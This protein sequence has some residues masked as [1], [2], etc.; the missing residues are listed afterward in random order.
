MDH[1]N[2]NIDNSK[3]LLGIPAFLM[4]VLSLVLTEILNIFKTC[5]GGFL[6]ACGMIFK[7]AT[8]MFLNMII[9]NPVYAVL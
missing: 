1:E 2:I 4:G 9:Y 7:V 5:F 8:T 6:V 3:I